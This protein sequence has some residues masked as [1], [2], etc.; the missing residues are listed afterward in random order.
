LSELPAVETMACT[1]H[2]G[3]FTTISEAY[4]A[5]A[6]WIESNSYRICGSS[7]EVYL[8]EAKPGGSGEMGAVSQ[9]DPDTVT[10]LQ[11]PVEKV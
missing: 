2:H 4:N 10:E 6:K 5:I 9:N 3:P 8:R 11:F 1:I 7:R